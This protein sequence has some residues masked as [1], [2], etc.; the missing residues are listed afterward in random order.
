ME[1]HYASDP[2]ASDAETWLTPSGDLDGD[3][4]TNLQAYWFG[5]DLLAYLN[6][7][8]MDG[9]GMTDAQEDYWGL[10]RA[11][12]ADSVLDPDGDGVMN[13]EEV[14]RSRSPVNNG[15]S[16]EVGRWVD[17]VRLVQFPQRA[18]RVVGTCDRS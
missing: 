12:F 5:W 14:A 8:D 1:K 18:L 11:V 16:L 4:V 7:Y 13:Y 10:D 3:G 17:T 9:D 6:Q 15:G 2:G